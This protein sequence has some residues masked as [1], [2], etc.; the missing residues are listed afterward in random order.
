MRVPTTRVLQGEGG[1]IL[2]RGTASAKSNVA[3]GGV[4]RVLTGGKDRWIVHRSDANLAARGVVS[5]VDQEGIKRGC[6]FR[7]RRGKHHRCC[8]GR[9]VGYVV[10]GTGGRAPGYVGPSGGRRRR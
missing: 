8:S 2:V 1:S 9:V 6:F 10:Y 5:V 4:L 7:A 3:A